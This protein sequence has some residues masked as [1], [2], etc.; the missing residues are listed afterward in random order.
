VLLE[1]AIN[2]VFPLQRFFEQCLLGIQSP[3]V[4]GRAG[5][6]EVVRW[7]LLPE[8]PGQQVEVIL[9]KLDFKCWPGT[10]KRRGTTYF[11]YSR[12]FMIASLP[13]AW[14][15]FCSMVHVSQ[16]LISNSFSSE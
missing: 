13:G 6:G 4:V 14:M 9:R 1:T 12:Y 15:I 10:W 8:L 7:D 3:E 16:G 11:P 5:G 2:I